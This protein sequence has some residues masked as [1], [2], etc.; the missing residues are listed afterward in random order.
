MHACL[1]FLVTIL[2]LFGF[3][4][5]TKKTLTI[6]FSTNKVVAIIFDG[7]VT[8]NGSNIILHIIKGPLMKINKIHGTYDLLILFIIF[9]I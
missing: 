6:A 8:S 1:R 4:K 9:F 7:D 2:K 3:K 5:N